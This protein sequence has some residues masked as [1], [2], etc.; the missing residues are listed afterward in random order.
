MSYIEL[1]TGHERRRP[2]T[3]E[4]KQAVLAAA[5][6]PGAVVREVARKADIQPSLIYRWRRDQL[7]RL[8]PPGFA[9]VMVAAPANR[10]ADRS[11]AAIEVA[12]NS[13]VRARILASTPP[14]LAAA[15]IKALVS[16]R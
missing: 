12:F 4:Q 1:I 3:E 6:A 16:G 2:W 13:K 10:R 7:T 11:E 15:I 8:P 14:A 9:E 5:F